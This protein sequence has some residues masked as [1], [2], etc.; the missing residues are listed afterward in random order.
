MENAYEVV[1]T[2]GTGF[3]GR[4]LIPNIVKLYSPKSIICFV[5][6]KETPFELAGRKVIQQQKIAIIQGNLVNGENI[7]KL[8]KNPKLIIHLAAQTDTA[9]TE[10]SVN[11][12]G[13]K[14][15]YDYYSKV[16]TQTH[17]I[18][19]STMVLAAGRLNC[20]KPIN[21]HTAVYPSNEYTRTKY[22]GEKYAIAA[23]KKAQF[24]LTIL[25]PNTIYGKNVRKNSLFDMLKCYILLNSPITRINWPGKSALIHVS[26]VVDAILRI[27]Q[28]PPKS[29]RYETYLLYGENLTISEMSE[30]MHKALSKNYQPINLPSIVWKLFSSLR[31]FI[32]RMESFLPNFLYNPLWRLSIIT[33]NSVDCKTD[34]LAKRLTKWHPK[35]LDQTV[36]DVI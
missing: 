35:K 5:Y 9:S 15:L 27:S 23:C 2:G 19:I 36:T 14:N 26:D 33:D 11:A 18:H 17:V 1:I 4:N 22:Q 30:T 7:D 21:E 31:P 16:S 8:P 12:I 10:H 25:R 24:K 6:N 32:F 3:V 34:K 28:K 20:K 29:S 13:T